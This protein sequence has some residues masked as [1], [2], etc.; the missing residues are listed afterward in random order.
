MVRRLVFV[1]VAGVVERFV[2]VD[3]AAESGQ[4]IKL[5]RELTDVFPAECTNNE[6]RGTHV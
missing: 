4:K 5:P 6:L 3:R 2:G 1:C